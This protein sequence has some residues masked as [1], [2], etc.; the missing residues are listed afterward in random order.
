M[1]Q[2][3][4]VLQLLWYS[5][6][7]HTIGERHLSSS[8]LRCDTGRESRVSHARAES[9]LHAVCCETSRIAWYEVLQ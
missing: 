8:A 5:G 3:L 9:C 6:W 1:P 2:M 7:Q 4:L